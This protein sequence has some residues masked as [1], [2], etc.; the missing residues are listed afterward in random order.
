MGER[1][2]FR[3]STGPKLAG[4]IEVPEK[5]ARGWGVFSHGFTLGKDCPAASRICKQLAGEGIGMLR[6][7]NLGLGD[8]E[9]DWGD[10]S[11]SHKVQDT[12]RAVEFMNGS[13]REVKLLVGHSFGGALTL[14]SGEGNAAIRAEVTF[15]A[16]AN[17][18]R[19]SLE[20]RQRLLTA[21]GK[22]SAPIMLIHAAN[23]YDTTPG[24][25]L[26]A[27]LER[28]NKPHI[29]KIYPPVGN[30][31]DDGHNFLYQDI[32][33]WEPDVI[34]FLDEHVKH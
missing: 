6:F 2:T 31:A 7:D 18:W 22:T 4:I 11:F 28:L 26:A 19:P 20:L 25:V 5:L 10:G 29:L 8:S 16:G 30:S 9:G 24:T 17:S 14:L 33:Q 21:V 12:V 15:G 32:P 1:V 23:D 34:N 27:K 3:S 13:G